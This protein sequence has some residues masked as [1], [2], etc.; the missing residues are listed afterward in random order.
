MVWK[1]TTL[2]RAVRGRRRRMLWAAT[3]LVLAVGCVACSASSGGT[4]GA[5]RGEKRLVWGK[6]AEADLLDPTLAGSG[7]AS[8]LLNLTYERLVDL[9]GNL[10]IVP[11]LAESWRQTS[12]T[13]YEFTLRR[14]VKF[15]NGRAMT[16]AD[17]TGTFDRVMDP[18]IGSLWASQLAIRSVTAKDDRHVT[19]TLT[20]P[21]T[22]FLA[23]L[24]ASRA[25]ILPMKELRA[26][27]FD[28]K[29]QLLGTGPFKVVAH[30][31]GE[32][33]TLVRNPY[34][35]QPG[36]P[37]IDKL[38][39]R[40]MPDDAARTAALRAGTIDVTT[41]E[42]PD[43]IRLLKGQAG[44]ITK[45][46]STTDFYR[47]DVNAKSSIFRDERL[48]QALALS[49]DRGAISRLVLA[50]VG[51]PTAAVSPVFSGVCDPATVPFAKPDVQRARQLVQSAGAAGKTVRIMTVAETPMAA[52]IAQLL[53]R[54]LQGAGLKVRIDRFD[55]G[56]ATK[57][58]YTGKSADFDLSVG[59]LFGYADP[60]MVVT[61]WNP[62][63]AA[64]TKAW[65]A[66]DGQL[67]ALI[68]RSTAATG[69]P[70]TQ[71][72]HNICDRIAQNANMIP[73]VSKDAIVAYRSDKIVPSIPPVEGYG[74]PLR[75][76]AEFG[77]K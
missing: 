16:A 47:L 24:A 17:V 40:I 74:V 76:L 8:E 34:Y 22:S 6:P 25:A 70:R 45:V 19:F 38:T 52:P 26:N 43:S 59:W 77:L 15:S 36:Q 56:E 27:T 46:Q 5:G 14:G 54:S 31:Q 61:W 55:I 44:I 23:A 3:A 35:W 69:A 53:Q 7:T 42:N 49:V 9:D 18:E 41:Y 33:W 28:P 63:L 29:K 13:T 67:N 71:T 30:S 66:P 65:M 39:I 12:P 51:R 32:S 21:R 68:K 64:F 1:L 75:H 37:K 50:G 10:K 48:R 60:G 72:L 11:K 20:Q 2:P 4:S 57:R 62:D 73:L 58:A